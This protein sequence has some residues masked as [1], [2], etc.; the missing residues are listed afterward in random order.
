M[1]IL[2]LPD[3][4]NPSF[5]VGP[6]DGTQVMREPALE[7]P[8][9][10]AEPANAATS[11]PTDTVTPEPAN[12]TIA[13]PATTVEIMADMDQDAALRRTSYERR[14]CRS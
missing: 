7:A 12:A 2:F 13:E 8:A 4:L 1:R 11:E 3:Y 6:D 5:R 10:S 9:S 14:R